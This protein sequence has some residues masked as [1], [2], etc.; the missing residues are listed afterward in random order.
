MEDSMTIGEIIDKIGSDAAVADELGVKE[1]AV[2][3]MRTRNSI[4]KW[5]WPAFTELA[6]RAG[7]TEVDIAYLVKVSVRQKQ[8]TIAASSK[9]RRDAAA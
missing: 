9:M 1:S 5:H 3:Q 4:A 8:C 7:L 2:R 6:Q